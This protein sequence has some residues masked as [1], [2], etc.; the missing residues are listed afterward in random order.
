[1]TIDATQLLG[2]FQKVVR[3]RVADATA[4]YFPRS[5]RVV[6]VADRNNFGAAFEALTEL[7]DYYGAEMEG[8]DVGHR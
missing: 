7:R 4:S 3:S 1:M 8:A 6:L 2:D 5:K